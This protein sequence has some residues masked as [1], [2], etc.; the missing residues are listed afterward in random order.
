MA[1]KRICSNVCPLFQVCDYFFDVQVELCNAHETEVWATKAGMLPSNMEMC[2]VLR[3]ISCGMTFAAAALAAFSNSA[4]LA[5]LFAMLWSNKD[6]IWG[7]HAPPA[8]LK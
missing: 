2:I 3:E 4:S 5:L 1:C 8:A 7:Q 6:S